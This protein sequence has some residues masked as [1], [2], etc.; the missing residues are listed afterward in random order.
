M[1]AAGEASSLLATTTAHG[2]RWPQDMKAT[3][4]ALHKI[5]FGQRREAMN[6]GAKLEI[7]ATGV[8]IIS[9]RDH[10]H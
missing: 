4:A 9:G 6:S 1:W 3:C 8:L 5:A 10:Q 7:T 2:C